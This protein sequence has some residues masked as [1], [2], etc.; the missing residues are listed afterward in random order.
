M[1]LSVL[2][3]G[4]LAG[5]TLVIAASWL[6]APA[7]VPFDEPAVREVFADR[8]G[9]QADRVVLS[10]DGRGALIGHAEG[11]GAVLQVGGRPWVREAVRLVWSAEGVAIETDEWGSPRQHLALKKERWDA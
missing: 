9:L 6:W 5:L 7:A 11:V 4:V 1:P 8:T 2:L 10:M 3:P